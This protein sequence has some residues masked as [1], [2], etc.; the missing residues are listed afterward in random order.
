MRKYLNKIRLLYEKIINDRKKRKVFIITTVAV[1]IILVVLISP[2]YSIFQ[3]TTDFN[4]IKGKIGNFNKYD[5]SLKVYIESIGLNGDGLGTYRLVSD[6]PDEGYQYNG[7]SCENN[8]TLVYD[9][10]SRNTSITL[11]E[12]DY[13]KIYF[14][15][16]N[17][18]DLSI[19]VMLEESVGS[20]KYT[21]STNIPFYGYEFSH[22]ICDNGGT[23]SYDGN[24]H[25][26]YLASA[27]AD[28][29]AVYF[30][31]KPADAEINLCIENEY[32]SGCYDTKTIPS[33]EVFILNS[34][35][36]C[37][38]ESGKVVDANIRYE[39][40]FIYIDTVEKVYCNI[41][42]DRPSE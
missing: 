10:S 32:H 8:G 34:K 18:A 1:V 4:V 36:N 37:V 24:L 23:L 11:T 19:T 15:Q 7:Y 29:C 20:N 21:E 42:L 30:T 31:K 35:S 28:H 22:H 9:A 40:G 25:K 13:C 2:S 33:N 39:D 41:Y 16:E 12:K 27:K 14:T 17:T 5:Y 6:I 38:N 26:V 3:E